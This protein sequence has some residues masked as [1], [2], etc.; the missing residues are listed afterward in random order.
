LAPLLLG[1]V[2]AARRVRVVALHYLDHYSTTNYPLK[3]GGHLISTER[4]RERERDCIPGGENNNDAAWPCSTLFEIH[5]P[6][7]DAQKFFL[8]VS[9]R[10]S[11]TSSTTIFFHL[12]NLPF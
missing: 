10:R 3:G 7:C 5:A 2:K 1:L 4:E 9:S 11:N 8:L 12:G 6:Q